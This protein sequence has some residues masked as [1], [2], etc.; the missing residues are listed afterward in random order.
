MSRLVSLTLAL[1]IGAIAVPLD[2]GAQE[3][4]NRR[5]TGIGIAATPAPGSYDVTAQWVIDLE[6]ST[7]V[8]LELGVDVEVSVN[9]V[10]GPSSSSPA[11]LLWDVTS[12]CVAQ[13]EGEPCGTVTIDTTAGALSCDAETETCRTPLLTALFPAVA[14]APG[15]E[16]AVSLTPASGSQPETATGDDQGSLEFG[17]WNRALDSV[18]VTPTSGAPPGTFDVTASI[19]L[20][21]TGSASVVL[22]LGLDTEPVADECCAE[23]CCCPPCSEACG[24]HGCVPIKIPGRT[25][26]QCLPTGCAGESCGQGELDGAP[27]DMQCTSGDCVCRSASLEITW[28]GVTLAPGAPLT[29][30]L[31]P[32]PGDLP[33]TQ[34]AD[35]SMV[36][37]VPGSRVPAVSAWSLGALALALLAAA[38]LQRRRAA[39]PK[40]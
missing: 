4:W 32:G 38:L 18:Q 37:T 24:G 36:V 33:E 21:L 30:V 20:E 14:L 2:A 6:G 7:T 16:L 39:E 15:E 40:L 1:F 34:T 17:A 27:F 19:T 25:T 12:S 9:S 28:P 8:P 22:P 35:D 31:R 11:A 10:P 13:P 3:T 26:A 5:V 23:A 29:L